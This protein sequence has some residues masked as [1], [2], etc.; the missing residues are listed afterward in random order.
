LQASVEKDLH[1][2]KQV[3]K[4]SSNI[5]MI[6]DHS[7]SNNIEDSKGQKCSKC[8]QYSY[9]VKTCQNII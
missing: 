7:V 9:Y 6:E 8:K 2:K 1:K 5:N 4:N 3:L